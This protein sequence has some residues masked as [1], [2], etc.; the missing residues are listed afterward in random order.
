MSQSMDQWMLN[1]LRTPR[2]APGTPKKD[3]EDAGVGGGAGL[4]ALNLPY[5]SQSP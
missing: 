2:A 4:E 1:N 3:K 5:F